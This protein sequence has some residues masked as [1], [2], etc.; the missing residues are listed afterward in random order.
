M[1]H[2]YKLSVYLFNIHLAG[3]DLLEQSPRTTTK[4]AS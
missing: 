4:K 2:A 1:N 3:T